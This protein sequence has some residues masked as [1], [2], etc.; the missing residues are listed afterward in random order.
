M[1]S[2]LV[3][4]ADTA[5]SKSVKVASLKEEVIRRLKY[6]S[7]NLPLAKSLET[8]EDMSQKMVNSGHKPNFMKNILIAGILKF[9]K[10]VKASQLTE[11]DPQCKP[12]NQPSG[13]N[14][15][16]M[17]RKVMAK[18]EWYKDKDD[19]EDSQEAGGADNGSYLR[20][21]KSKIKNLRKQ[22]RL[23]TREETKD[24]RG[25]ETTTVMFIQSSKREI[26][27][28][29]LKEKERYWS[30]L[31]GF[32]VKYVKS[33]GTPLGNLLSVDHSKGMKCGRDICPPCKINEEE[34]RQNCRLRSVL[35]ETSCMICNPTVQKTRTSS[36]QEGRRGVYI[37]ETSRSLAER[38]LE[39]LGDVKSFDSGSHILKHWMEEHPSLKN[40]PPFRF[41]ITRT[42]SDCLTRQLA[43]AIRIMLSQEQGTKILNGKNEYLNNNIPRVKVDDDD[44]ERKKREIREEIEKKEELVRIEKFKS[45][46]LQFIQGQQRFREINTLEED[47]L[48]VIRNKK[49]KISNH[50]EVSLLTS[51]PQ[52]MRKP[53]M[54]EYQ[55]KPLAIEY[56][57]CLAI[58]FSQEEKTTSNSRIIQEDVHGLGATAT[59]TP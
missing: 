37:G 17:R 32:K 27:I 36:L 28:N 16:R 26:L 30:E 52:N 42:F 2:N 15:K 5:L 23:V 33:A 40:I 11:N 38:S 47:P 3:L 43:E 41:R 4:Q 29:T 18:A 58:E 39:H 14:M 24:T 35:Y 10:K 25:L 13:G 34:V 46:K 54:I 57:S 12:L 53:L 59:T 31:S 20:D 55:K 45:E 50:K 44:I 1:A 56:H 48:K 51:I 9:D 19:N 7:L 49:L 6:T 21:A 8:L 22:K